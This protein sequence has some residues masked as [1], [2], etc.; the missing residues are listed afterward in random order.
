M[1]KERWIALLILIMSSISVSNAALDSIPMGPY[2]VSFDIGQHREVD[3]RVSNV[4]ITPWE[5]P[6]GNLETFYHAGLGNKKSL[7]DADIVII[8]ADLPYKSSMSGSDMK[9]FMESIFSS[10]WTPLRWSERTIDKAP[11]ELAELKN[12][13]GAHRYMAAFMLPN[14]D[15]T[16][17]LI[18]SNWPWHPDTTNLLDSIHIERIINDR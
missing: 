2:K 10:Y 17:V 11:G 7:L 18:S 5:T 12:S 15:N 16:I 8:H 6:N 4:T 13:E 9:S 3:Y 14:E 1:E